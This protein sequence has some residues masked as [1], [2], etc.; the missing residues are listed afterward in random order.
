[1]FDH[2]CITVIIQDYENR[3]TRI[4]HNSNT[5]EI[6]TG[7]ESPKKSNYVRKTGPGNGDSSTTKGESVENNNCP[8]ANAED[9]KSDYSENFI[10][11]PNS[12][13]TGQ[14]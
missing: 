13:N 12:F 8:F 11:G 2:F 9:T 5:L 14:F 4:F 10:N 7:N 6:E 3:S 1:M